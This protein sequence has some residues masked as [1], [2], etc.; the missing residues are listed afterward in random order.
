MHSAQP[1]FVSIRAF[2]AEQWTQRLTSMRLSAARC[3]VCKA[4]EIEIES[5][6]RIRILMSE[7]MKETNQNDLRE[8]RNPNGNEKISIYSKT[9]TNIKLKLDIFK[10]RCTSR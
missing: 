5:A 3:P 6:T 1:G 9:E 10:V 8:N 4:S 2:P 7:F